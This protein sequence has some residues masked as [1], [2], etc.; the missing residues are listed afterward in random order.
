MIAAGER[1]RA[2]SAERSAADV[3]IVGCGCPHRRDDQIGL[4]VAEVFRERPIPGARVL[5]SQ[6]PGADL[7]AELA[8]VGL[9]VIVDAAKRPGK[10]P[11]G[12]YRRWIVPSPETPACRSMLSEW[13]G[14]GAASSHLLSVCDAL[15]LG[16]Q[17]GLLPPEV[18]MYAIAV[19]DCGYGDALSESLRSKIDELAAAVRRDIEM[20]RP[21]PGAADA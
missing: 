4:R 13:S 14:G 7:L 1:N 12:Y 16:E 2:H 10:H 3:L 11:V 21:T 15:C 9:L 17:L 6:A 19:E 8:D 5:E 20:W 18:W